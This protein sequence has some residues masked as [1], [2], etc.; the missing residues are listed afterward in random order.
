MSSLNRPGGESKHENPDLTTALAAAEQGFCIF[1]T[2]PYS[3]KPGVSSWSEWATCNLKY[4]RRNWPDNGANVAVACKPSGLL[5]VDLDRHEHDGVAEW[6][7]LAAGTYHQS[8]KCDR[9]YCV[10]ELHWPDTYTVQTPT[11]GYHLYFLNPDPKRYG[12][13]RGG[14]PDGIDVRGGGRGYG[15][16]V[17][18]AGS[19]VDRRAYEG[20]PELQEL[21]G[22][23]KPYVVYND[24]EVIEPPDWITG[25][26]DRKPRRKRTPGQTGAV[27]R[28]LIPVKI[29]PTARLEKR[30]NGALDLLASEAEGNRNHL[31]YWASKIFGQVVAAGRMTYEDAEKDLLE[32]MGD[33]GYLSEHDESTAVGTIIS[34]MREAGVL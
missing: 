8:H 2:L 30:L 24:A 1:P 32:A 23:G 13:G 20:K 19:V 27:N 6:S 29:E 26:L 21:V 22:D 33:N 10:P 3:K 16:Y 15:G 11:G 4:I 5:V 25:L 18:A 7:A 31:L 17:L 14:L 9:R 34:G 12:N 28:A